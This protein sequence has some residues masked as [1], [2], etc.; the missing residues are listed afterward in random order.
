MIRGYYLGCPGWG[1]KSWVGRLFPPGTRST[2][3]L[4]RYA[5]VFNTVEGNTTFYAL[6]AAETVDRWRA[7]VPD[8]FRFCFKFPRTITHDKQLAGCEAEVDEFIARWPMQRAE[9]HVPEG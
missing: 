5:E 9:E 8:Q 4:E 6:P 3:F 2:E 7:Q 1:L